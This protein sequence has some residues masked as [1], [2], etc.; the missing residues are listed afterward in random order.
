M[1]TQP[2]AR[3][4]TE[5]FDHENGQYQ[6]RCITC[7]NLFIGHKRRLVCK[8]CSGKGAMDF[9]KEG[10]LY[11]AR[12]LNASTVNGNSPQHALYEVEDKAKNMRTIPDL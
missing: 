2:H 1:P 9:F 5:D 12:I 6:C 8:V 11:A 4:W 10:M 7:N 3:D